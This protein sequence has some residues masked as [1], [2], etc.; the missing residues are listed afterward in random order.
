MV[1]A[2]AAPRRHDHRLPRDARLGAGAQAVTSRCASRAP[3]ERPRLHQPR[4]GRRLQ[5]LPGR[6]AAAPTTLRRASRPRAGRRGSI[7]AGS[8]GRSRSRSRSRRSTRPARSPTSTQ[9]GR[10]FRRASARARAGGLGAGA[11]RGRDRRAR[12]DAHRR[13]TPRS[14]TRCSRPACSW[15]PTAAIAAPTMQVHQA[16]GFTFHSTFSLWDTFRAE[17]PL[18]TLVQPEQRNSDFVNSLLAS[19]K[20]ARTASCRSGSSTGRRPGP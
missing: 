11:R 10:R 17:H 4:G 13:S 5:G 19:R 20:T 18:L 6:P 14:T 9:R 16:E 8:T 2:A 15:T 1:V 7:S 3:L 12:A